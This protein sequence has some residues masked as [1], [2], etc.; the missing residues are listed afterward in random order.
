MLYKTKA[1]AFN[2]IKYRETSIISRVYTREFGLQSYIVNGVRSS[3]A[4]SKIAHYQPFTLL[5]IVCYHNQKKDIQR[6]SEIKICEALHSIP[7]DIAKTSI[8]LFLT[9]IM[10]KIFKEEQEDYPQFDFIYHAVQILDSMEL[11]ISHFHL[12]FLLKLGRFIGIVPSGAKELLDEIA[13]FHHKS[14][15]NTIEQI[16]QLMDQNFGGE[17]TMGKNEKLNNLDLII[18]LY[19]HHFDQLKE[20]KTLSVLREIMT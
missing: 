5:D 17:I 9:E 19:Q 6:I 15:D 4:K 13:Y 20:I 11:G 16:Q 12:Q 1:I 18:S 3:K 7:F 8:A 2:Y 10:V 14:G